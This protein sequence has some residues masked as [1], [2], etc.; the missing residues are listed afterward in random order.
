[1]FGR[2]VVAEKLARMAGLINEPIMKQSS[3][4]ETVECSKA[5][6]KKR[7]TNKFVLRGEEKHA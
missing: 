6:Q 5:P 2:E 1:M 4:A 7:I 3:P